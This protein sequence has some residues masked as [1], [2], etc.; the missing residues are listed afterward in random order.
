MKSRCLN[1]NWP[2]FHRYGGRG[3]AVCERWM[4]FDN[5]LA[6]MGEPPPGLT[7]DRINNN[8]G[9]GPD[10]YR[11][12][13]PKTQQR[14]MRR[15]RIMTF[16][17]KTQTAVEWAEELGINEHTIYTRLFKGWSDEEALG[18]PVRKRGGAA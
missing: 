5:F 7:L 18:I 10:N 9:Y 6:D 12:V 2:A 16:Q 17:G 15:N 14:N 3:I 11:W 4:T 13:A 8:E 1:P